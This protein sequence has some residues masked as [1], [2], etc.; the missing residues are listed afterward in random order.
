MLFKL[1]L[2]QQHMEEDIFFL[3]S[4]QKLPGILRKTFRIFYPK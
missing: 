1:K 2:H 3:Q 4:E